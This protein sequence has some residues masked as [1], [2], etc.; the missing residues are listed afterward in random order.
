MRIRRHD[1]HERIFGGRDAVTTIEEG[2]TSRPQ[3]ILPN[4]LY[5][6]GNLTAWDE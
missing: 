5:V 4:F 1:S 2:L 6:S 3:S